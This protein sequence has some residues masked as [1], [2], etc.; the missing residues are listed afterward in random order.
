[1]SEIENAELTEEFTF[2]LTPI[3]IKVKVGERHYILREATG[4]AAR[5]YRNQMTDCLT[6]GDSGKPR[7]VSGIASLEPLLVSLCL[8]DQAG[9]LVPESILIKW[10]ARIL[11][12]LY[13][14]A[15]LISLIDDEDETVESLTKERDK[16]DKKLKELA[17]E[18]SSK[19]SSDTEGGS[20]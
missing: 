18:G 20:D 14:K 3:E 8:F 12:K 15:K 4:E 7:K 2:D 11:R 6:L 17:D 16:L 13:D 19:N 10:P 9:N 5:T 1:M